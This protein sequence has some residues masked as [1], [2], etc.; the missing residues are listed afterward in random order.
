MGII[1]SGEDWPLLSQAGGAKRDQDCR[2]ERTHKS[3]VAPLSVLIQ[4]RALDEHIEGDNFERRFVSGFEAH[5][6]HDASIEGPLPWAHANAPAIPRFEAGETIF[7][8]RRDQVIADGLLMA[9]ELVIHDDADRMLAA[10]VRAGVALA[11]AIKAGD[12]IGAAS[13]EDSSKYV[14]DHESQEY[15]AAC[16]FRKQRPRKSARFCRWKGNDR[17]VNDTAVPFGFDVTQQL[18]DVEARMK[19]LEPGNLAVLQMIEREVQAR[20]EEMAVRLRREIEQEHIC[21]I[22]AFV[23]KVQEKLVRRITALEEAMNRQALATNEIGENCLR[24]DDNLSRINSGI[25]KLTRAMS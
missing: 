10:V 9:Q 25:E 8:M 20:V 19:A 6:C 5:G 17:M 7:R 22:E 15:R 1:G 12:G 24:T 14:F 2:Y 16:G 21:S 4:T 13:L 3:S 18:R 23:R 11:V